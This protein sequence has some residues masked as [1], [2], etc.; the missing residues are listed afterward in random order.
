MPATHLDPSM[1]NAMKFRCIGPPRGGRVL[2]VAGHPTELATFY[3]GAC[4][5]GVWKSDDAGQYWDNISDGFFTSAAVGAIA[6]APSDPNVIYVGTGEATLRLDVSYGDGVYKSTDGGKTWANV[7]L[8][9]TKHI[10]KIRIHPQNPDL[11]YVAALGHGFGP[12]PERGV[13]RSRDGGATW[14]Q[15]LFVSDKAGAVDLSMD[16]ANP[17][18]L[19]AS[20]YETYRHFW[21]LSS[22]GPDSGL[23][24]STDGGDTWA[25]LTGNKGLPDGLKGKIGVAV[26][27]PQPARVWAMVEA[28][29]AKAGLYRSDDDG[30][31]WQLMSNN[32]DLI[33]RPWYYCHV[34][35]DPQDADTVYILNLKMWKSVDGG[36]TFTEITTPHGDNHDLWIDPQ[37]PR[38]MV[39]GND[40]G[41][42]VSFNGGASWST[43]YNQ[44]TS[45]FYHVATDTRYPYHVYGTQQD[46]SSIAVPSSTEKGAISWADCFP[47]GTGESG[48]I[49]VR[50][51][52]PNI[53]YVGAIGSSPGGGNALQRYDHRTK[54]VRLITVYPEVPLGRDPSDLKYRF[55][56]TYPIVISPH[57]PDTL[58][59]T[60]NHVFKSTN[61]GESWTIISPDLSRQDPE[62]L[63]ASGGAITLDTSGAEIYG[64]VF[65]FAESPHT[66]G[67]FWAG[68]DDGLVH[69]SHDAGD[70][71]TAITPPD[72][73]EWTLIS[74]IEPSPH[75]EGVA[76]VA[77]TRYKLD[78][79]RPFIYK[80][81][82]FGQTWTSLSASFP[83]DEISRVVREDPTV[84]GLLYVGSETGLF[85]SL[86]DGASWQ[87]FSGN[88][89]V[90][91][92]YDLVVKG[93]DLVIGTHGRSF[94]ILDDVTPLR[95]AATGAMG[96]GAHLIAPRTTTRLWEGW[97]VGAFRGPGKNYMLG[98]GNTVT[99]SESKDE[100]G[101][102][103][104]RVWDGGVNPPNGVIIY[105]TLPA[106][107]DGPVSLTILEEDGTE[108]RSYGQRTPETPA[109]TRTIATQ[110]GLNRF[111][112]DMRYSNATVVPGDLPTEKT[113]VGPRAAPGTYQVRLTVG[114][115]SE[116]ATFAIVPDPRIRAEQ[117]DLDA[118]FALWTQVRDK[119][120]ETHAAINKLRDLRAQAKTWADR[121][122]VHEV[123]TAATALVDTLN[124]IEEQLI[125]TGSMTAGDR[126]RLPARLNGMLINLVSVISAADAKPTQQTYDAFADLSAQ[127]DVQLAALQQA[128]DTD[129]AAL[130]DLLKRNETPYIKL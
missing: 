8:R 25:E 88:F 7:G 61:E 31:T 75:A 98:L 10:A 16:P 67:V 80:T 126:L 129:V 78:D 84:P 26:S 81:T 72:L 73:P 40:G 66:A 102:V 115:Q 20:V 60:G 38:R 49:A 33:H 18:I 108:I 69:I 91:P 19:Y 83:Q 125:Q 110:P 21:T 104:R 87:R 30:K 6:V 48:Y 117:V 93:S 14:E 123:K 120:T 4:A 68:T 124:G 2:A 32:R 23:W 57:D 52:D 103:Q 121:S 59:V 114:E 105:Y 74:M 12:N 95:Q 94:W 100:H 15:V 64:T 22:G 5:G 116:T 90:V 106:E 37:N 92:V 44:V 9:D 43:I 65:A 53:V 11:V 51:D 71:W 41:A 3:F 24:K 47:A 119:I 39:Q 17:R 27:P 42:C 29:G 58:F 76:Y 82:D 63:K 107:F 46:N 112:W 28:E 101:E 111:I 34:F 86:D 96:D 122:D 1:L 77:A 130:S 45:Q 36:K 128:L 99:F 62:K 118:Q 70:T 97:S 55:A 54:Q 50:P 13:Y 35:A 79:Y 89:P 113:D 109:D 127:V 85:F 56:W